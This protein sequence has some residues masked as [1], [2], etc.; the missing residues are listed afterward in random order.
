MHREQESFP[1]TKTEDALNY[2]LA[3]IHTALILGDVTEA[4][5]HPSEC[6]LKENMMIRALTLQGVYFRLLN[7]ALYLGH[8]HSGTTTAQV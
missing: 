1:D 7:S 6:S 8:Q 4:T 5:V 3:F 2:H